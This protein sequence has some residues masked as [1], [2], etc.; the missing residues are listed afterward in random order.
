MKAVIV[1]DEPIL[2]EALEEKI[3]AVNPECEI[4]AKLTGVEDTIH[5]IKSNPGPCLMFM[6]I[7]LSDGI[8]FSIFDSV[9]M[10]NKVI[11]FTTA[12]DEYVLDAFDYNSVAYLLKPVKEEELLKIFEKI[13]NIKDTFSVEKSISLIQKSFEEIKGEA[14]L[15]KGYRQRFLVP[16][17]DGYIQMSVNDI[18]FF[19][20]IEKVTHAVTFSGKVEIIDF[21]LERLEKEL[22]PDIFF[23]ANRQVIVN[24]NAVAR[25]ENYFGG[26][27]IVK[28]DG[29]NSD[30]KITVSR[31]RAGKFKKWLDR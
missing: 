30:E 21:S 28:I 24:I 9:D 12:Y 6:D 31:L 27:L 16:K 25:I 5:W 29:S 22:D 15:Q 20:V 7:Q 2:A 18:A 11:V 14:M 26:K 1:E 17:G 4:V 19:N 3:A 13:E 10:T 8:C 23:R